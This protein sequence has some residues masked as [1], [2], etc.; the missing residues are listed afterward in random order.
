M[1]TAAF[2]KI[3]SVLSTLQLLLVVV[4]VHGFTLPRSPS[5]TSTTT[6]LKVVGQQAESFGPASVLRSLKRELPQIDWLAQGEGNPDNKIN[7]PPYVQQVLSQPEAPQREAEHADRTQRIRSRFEE[8]ADDARA[9]RGMCVGEYD[10]KAWWRSPGS[11]GQRLV[12][13]EQPLRVLIAGGGLAGL[14]AAAACHAKG[15]KVAIFEQASSYAPYGGPIQIQSNA[16]RAIQRISPKCYE[17]LVQAGTVTA[18]RVSGLKIGYRKGNKL[19]GLYDA[20]DWLVRFDTVG[21]ALEAGLPATVVVDRPVIQ[22][23]MVQH[24]IPEGAVRI[25]S[26]IESYETNAQDGTIVA[27]LKDGTKTYGDVLIGA[28][29]IWSQIRK[30]MHGLDEGAGGFAASGAAG[31]ALD[32]REARKLAKDTVK[33]AQKAARRYSGFTCYASL[34]DHRA[35]NIED[36]SYQILLGEKKYFVSTDGGGERQQ[37]FA[38]IREPA[39]GIDPEPTEDDPHPKLTRLR[40]EFASLGSGGDADGNEWDPFGL[41]LI[42]ASNEDDIKRRDLYDGAPLL[43]TVDPQRL[44]SPWAKGPVALCGDAVHPMMPNLGQGGCQATE[45]GFRL[46]EELAKVR[47]TDDIA[48]ALG[49]YSRVRVIRTSIIQGF[50]QLGSDLLVDFD[51]MMTIPILGPFF[52]RMTQLSMPWVLRFL[53]TAEF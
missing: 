20:G 6:S 5:S 33:I 35:S 51:L 50:A 19:A 12:T 4:H 13:P 28:D 26:R 8:A 23:I 14:V 47:H 48:G 52:L 49:Q 39:G 1:T 11:P 38:L 21:P 24:G 9:L 44:W 43:A 7:I 15:M 41:E 34:A 10:D 29:G 16:L 46:A 17:E 25:Q 40:K 36:V 53:Y 2:V 30:L 45:D 32:D 3:V 42:N 27:T 18:D 22:Q 31:G 37:W